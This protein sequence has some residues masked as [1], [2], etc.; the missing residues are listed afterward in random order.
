[1]IS[2][3]RAT[4]DDYILL[5]QWLNDSEVRKNSFSQEIVKLENHIKW[6]Q[7]KL[8]DDKNNIFIVMKD[9]VEVGQIRVEI[10]NDV[11]TISYSID[12]NY[13]GQ[14]IGTEILNL[15]KLEFEDIKLIGY[16]KKD[17]IAS[18]K[19]FEKAGYKK[20][21]YNDFIEFIYEPNSK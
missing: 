4:S 20:V 9:K 19:V 7:S 21:E 1:M 6:F 3:R 10:D 8:K 17:N 15:I 11:G 13:R 16:V 18:I 2:L 14:G 12:S 5:F